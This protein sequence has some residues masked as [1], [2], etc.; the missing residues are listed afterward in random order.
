[1]ASSKKFYWKKMGLASDVILKTNDDGSKVFAEFEDFGSPTGSYPL[2]YAV[3]D[4]DA[5]K[6][7]QAVDGMYGISKGTQAQYEELKKKLPSSPSEP[8]WRE[9][10]KA[11]SVQKS[12]NVAEVAA[13]GSEPAAAAVQEQAQAEPLP[14]D[15]KPKVGKRK[16]TADSED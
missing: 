14:E 8:L 9:E 10:I 3:V 16:A 4:E 7:Y 1:M 11:G 2:G 6:L 13:G 5:N 15:S 12:K